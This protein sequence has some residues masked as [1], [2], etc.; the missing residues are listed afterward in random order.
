MDCRCW[1]RPRRQ[2]APWPA[3]RIRS[4]STSARL[5]ASNYA[6]KGVNG[7][8]TVVPAASFTTL[9]LA[10]PALPGQATTF[11]AA[12]QF[13]KGAVTEGNVTFT[14]GGVPL[15]TVAVTTALP[16]SARSFRRAQHA[17]R[18]NYSGGPDFVGSS[19]NT[20]AVAIALPLTGDV[21]SHV[22]VQLASP[23]RVRKGRAYTETVT[24][25]VIPG[26]VIEGPLFFILKGLKN[27]VRLT[28]ASGKTHSFKRTKYSYMRI[29]VGGT[30]LLSGSTGP[31]QLVFNARP[32]KFKPMV[33]AGPAAP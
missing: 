19:S 15:G 12:I 2:E 1:R 26:Q 5:T 6:F 24:I 20:L 32:N 9:A 8:L 29:A 14:D 27:S 22:I 13:A 33:W 10:G 4:R 18:A 11:T 28:N 3:A 7:Q 17:I 25:T 30:G 23:V 31:R 21:T 16:A